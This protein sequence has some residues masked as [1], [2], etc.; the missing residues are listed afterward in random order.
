MKSNDYTKGCEILH[1]LSEIGK[2]IDRM[3]IPMEEKAL[4]ISSL[5]QPH[6]TINLWLIR[7]REEAENDKGKVVG[8]WQFS[9]YV[10]MVIF[11]QNKELE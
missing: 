10:K 9:K 1:K 3:S 4:L 6:D 2:D 5:K 11:G 8:F 7:G